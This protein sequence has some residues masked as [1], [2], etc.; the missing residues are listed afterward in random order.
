MGKV[1]KIGN[2]WT[3]TDFKLSDSSQI[4]LKV[5]LVTNCTISDSSTYFL[6]H[7]YTKKYKCRSWEYQ[8]PYKDIESLLI[9]YNNDLVRQQVYTALYNHWE[10]INPIRMFATNNIGNEMTDFSVEELKTEK[11]ICL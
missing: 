11:H 3:I 9:T 5:G 2:V 8:G 6:I 4:R 1:S 7:V 10:Q